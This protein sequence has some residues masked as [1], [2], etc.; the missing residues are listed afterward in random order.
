L[1]VNVS[2]VLAHLVPALAAAGDA[3]GWRYVEF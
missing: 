3:A 1:P 2:K